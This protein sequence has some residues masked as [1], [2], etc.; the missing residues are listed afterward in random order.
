MVYP[1]LLPLMRTHRLPV[2]NWTGSPRRFKWTRP[3]RRKTKY[4]FCACA[5][6]FQ[7]QSTST[8]PVCLHWHVMGRPLS[9]LITSDLGCLFPVPS[10]RHFNWSRESDWSV[11][12][13]LHRL[14][15]GAPFEICCGFQKI[16]DTTIP[17]PISVQYRGNK[18]R[19]SSRLHRASMIINTLLS[20]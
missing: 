17:P 9:W 20:N 3:F 7:T 10:D 18:Q 2:V 19:G 4:G 1:V 12:W 8:Y 15:Q 5:I 16:R 14:K 13:P 6:T 11:S